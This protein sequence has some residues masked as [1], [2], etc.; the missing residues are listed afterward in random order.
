MLKAFERKFP[1]INITDMWESVGKFEN[2]TLMDMGVLYF[3]IEYIFLS[4]EET[5]GIWCGAYGL[6][7]GGEMASRSL[8]LNIGK[9]ILY[10]MVKFFAKI[11]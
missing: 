9:G 10:I 5:K 4:I 1:S 11:I 7:V 8:E 3:F 6:S 2:S